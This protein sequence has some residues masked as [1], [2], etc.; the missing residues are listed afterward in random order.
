MDQRRIDVLIKQAFKL[1]Q[2]AKGQRILADR[3]VAIECNL[4]EC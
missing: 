3:Q 1:G 4:G 2:N